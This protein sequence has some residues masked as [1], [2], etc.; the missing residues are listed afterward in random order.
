MDYLHEENQVLREQP[1]GRQ[2][3]FNDDQRGRL[4]VKAKALGRK[5]LTEFA[6]SIPS[7]CT[8]LSSFIFIPNS[9]AAKDQSMR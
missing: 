3:R 2:L 5:I 7:I 6:C 9:N 4:A 1:G 8:R